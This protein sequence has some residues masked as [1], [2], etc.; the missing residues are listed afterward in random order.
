MLT[1]KYDDLNRERA[2]LSD[3]LEESRTAFTES[4][5]KVNSLKEEVDG[6]REV[7]AEQGRKLADCARDLST[8]Q[9]QLEELQKEMA[10]EKQKNEA[11]FT[12]VETYNKKQKD[13]EDQLNESR[14][15]LNVDKEDLTEQKTMNSLMADSVSFILK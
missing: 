6:C 7:I 2:T 11:F 13:Y 10:N 14:R 3:W 8:R 9:G 5:N 12:Q 1:E 4:Q 15:Q